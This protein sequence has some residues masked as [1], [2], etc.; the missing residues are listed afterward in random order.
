VRKHHIVG[1]CVRKKTAVKT[2]ND[3][4]DSKASPAPMKR[5]M[6]ANMLKRYSGFRQTE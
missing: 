6:Q 2:A 4:S 5:N 3:V 1:Q